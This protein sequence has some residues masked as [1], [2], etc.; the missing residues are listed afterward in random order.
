MKK[1]GESFLSQYANPCSFLCRHA[2]EL[3][4]KQCLSRQNNPITTSHKILDLWK[5][6]DKNKLD[7]IT[8]SKLDSFLSEVACIDPNGEYIRYG[9]G[10]DSLPINH[11]IVSFDCVLLVQ[12]TMYL[13]NQLHRIVF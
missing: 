11:K 12:N 13:F 5:K 4:L 3:K 7:S 8:I 6:I 9:T 1:S 2:I 10:K